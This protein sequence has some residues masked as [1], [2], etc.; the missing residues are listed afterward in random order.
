[1]YQLDKEGKKNK[2]GNVPFVT[3]IMSIIEQSGGARQVCTFS[4]LFIV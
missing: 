3:W 1:M 2:G 4:F